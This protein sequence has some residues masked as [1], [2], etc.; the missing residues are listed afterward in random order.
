M[1]YYSIVSAEA[2]FRQEKDG[3]KKRPETVLPIGAPSCSALAPSEALKVLKK[4]RKYV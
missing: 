2:V 3:E 4:E 1:I